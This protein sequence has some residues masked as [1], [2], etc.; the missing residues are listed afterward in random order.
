MIKK[1]TE[2]RVLDKYRVWLRFDDGIEGEV[3]F[4]GKPRTG[5]Y[6]PWEDYDYFRRAQV[7]PS[8]ELVWDDQV[9]FSPTSIHHPIFMRSTASFQHRSRFTAGH[10]PGQP[11]PT[12]AGLCR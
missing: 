5:V 6:V 11:S 9:D 7:G 8:G 12:G 3:D 2:V 1:L 4:S 10:N